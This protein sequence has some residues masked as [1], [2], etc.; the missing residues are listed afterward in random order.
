MFEYVDFKNVNEKTL[1]KFIEKFSMNDLKL[2]I[3][4]LICRRLL[5]SND[6]KNYSKRCIDKIIEKHHIQGQEFKGILRY[7]SDESGGNIHD[8]GV[9]EI[10]PNSAPNSN[11]QPKNVVN[12]QE[13]N[14]YETSS[15]IKN[16]KLCFDF[17]K[18]K[19]QVTNYSIKTSV[20]G[21]HLKNI[22]LNTVLYIIWTMWKKFGNI[23]LKMSLVLIHRNTLS[24]LQSHCR[25]LKPIVKG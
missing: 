21:F 7:L 3:W 11:C 14:Y 15:S 25:I 5:S 17:K 6:S 18:N 23:R 20:S 22:L 10:T 19:I 16:A 4:K 2:G 9:V 1:E 24:F 8:K 13:N 12:Y